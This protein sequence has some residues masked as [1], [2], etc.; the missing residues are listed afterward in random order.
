MDA[1]NVVEKP[2]LID[3]C[4]PV[5]E[6]EKGIKIPIGNAVTMV[7]LRVM[8]IKPWRVKA[9]RLQYDHAWSGREARRSLPN[10]Y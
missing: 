9:V 10:N 4:A 2:G 8:G 7:V 3:K 5:E 6:T 1:S